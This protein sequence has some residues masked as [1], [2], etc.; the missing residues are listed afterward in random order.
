MRAGETCDYPVTAV[1][2]WCALPE[3]PDITVYI[4]KRQALVQGRVLQRAR[5]LNAFVLREWTE[6]LCTEADL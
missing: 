4:E 3:L 1:A 6:R 5:M 2:D